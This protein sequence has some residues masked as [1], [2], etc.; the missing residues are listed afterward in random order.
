MSTQRALIVDD[1]EVLRRLIE[2]CLRPAGFEVAAAANGTEALEKASSFQPDLVILDIGLPDM[3]GWEVLEALRASEET[4]SAKVMILSGYEDANSEAKRLGADA[5]LVKPFRND[6]L[7][8][9]AIDL[10]GP[11]LT[12]ASPA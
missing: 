9:L 7:R 8:S 2:M 12:E 4:A 1:S 5:A 6:E 11:R 3:T 10:A